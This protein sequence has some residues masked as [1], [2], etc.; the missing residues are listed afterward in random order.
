M[1]SRIY[2]SGSD[3]RK[4]RKQDEEWQKGA[5]NKVPKLTQ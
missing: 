1:E 4:K 2:K 3:K 5:L